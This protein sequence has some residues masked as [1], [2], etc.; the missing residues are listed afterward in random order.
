MEIRLRRIWKSDFNP[1]NLPK[2]SRLTCHPLTIDD[3]ASYRRSTFSRACLDY[4]ACQTRAARQ[5][6]WTRIMIF[7]PYK[8]DDVTNKMHYIATHISGRLQARWISPTWTG[9]AYKFRVS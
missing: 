6:E 2:L 7:P 3:W 8:P 1:S 4:P 5:Q 9:E